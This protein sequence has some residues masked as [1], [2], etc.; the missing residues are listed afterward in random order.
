MNLD[1][2]R[3]VVGDSQHRI[4]DAERPFPEGQGR[5]RSSR[6]P[7]TCRWSSCD[8]RLRCRPE[9]REARRESARP[10]GRS[11]AAALGGTDRE[12]VARRQR[13][14]SGP[15]STSTMMARTGMWL[16]PWRTVGFTLSCTAPP[17]RPVTVLSSGQQASA[18]AAAVSMTWTRHVGRNDARHAQ[19]PRRRFAD[20][21]LRNRRDT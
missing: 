6:R 17:A 16:T 11:A 5:A 19:P 14:A 13:P 20:D 9:L 3:R 8:R 7:R 18:R 2:H 21:R 1:L 4:A 12:V 15:L 10:R